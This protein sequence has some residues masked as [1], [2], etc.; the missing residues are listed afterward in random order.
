VTKRPRSFEHRYRWM[1]VAMVGLFALAFAIG[2]GLHLTNPGSESA[3]FALHAGLILLM[4]SP[5]VRMSVATAERLRK[6]DFAFV[7][8][9]VVVLLELAIVLWRAS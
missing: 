4:V 5:A 3:R 8:M 6:R 2:L 7:V 1:S 9:T